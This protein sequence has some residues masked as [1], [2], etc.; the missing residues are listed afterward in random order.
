MLVQWTTE[1]YLFHM[2]RIFLGYRYTLMDVY[3]IKELFG[4]K[5]LG[6]YTV[7]LSKIELGFWM[8]IT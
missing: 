4:L 3:V 1:T 7:C 6:A 8:E 5:W 2:S